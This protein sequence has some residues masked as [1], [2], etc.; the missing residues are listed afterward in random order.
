MAQAL[1]IDV[2]TIFEYAELLAS[3]P[4]VSHMSWRKMITALNAED[5]S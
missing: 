3:E 5:Y 1:G 4:A 2:E